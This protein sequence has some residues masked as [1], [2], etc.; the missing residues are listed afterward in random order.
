MRKQRILFAGFVSCT[1]EERLPQRSIFGE[2]LGVRASQGVKSRTSCAYE[3]GYAALWNQ[4]RRVAK[5]CS[6]ARRWFRRVEEE[7]QLLFFRNDVRWRD[8]E[9][10]S[11]AP[12]ARQPRRLSAYQNHRGKGGWREGG[13]RGGGCGDG[14]GGGG[15]RRGGVMPKRLKSGSGH[16]CLDIW[17]PSNS[18]HKLA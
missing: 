11:D 1:G 7:T 18:R 3:G 14:G 4:V 6:A 5:G 13:R 9:L 2:L 10:Q 17:C 15:G 12:R 16:H 8:A